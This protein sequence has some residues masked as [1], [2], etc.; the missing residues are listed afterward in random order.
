MRGF[1]LNFTL[2][3][4]N[5]FFML[6]HHQTQKPITDLE[7]ERQ[8]AYILFH[9]LCWLPAVLNSSSHLACL[10]LFPPCCTRPTDT[11]ASTDMHSFL[12]SIFEGEHLFYFFLRVFDLISYSNSIHFL[13]NFKLNFSLE[14]RSILFTC[15]PDYHYSRTGWQDGCAVPFPCVVNRAADREQGA[16]ISV[17][18]CEPLWEHAQEWNGWATK[19]SIFIFLSN[20]QTDFPDGCMSAY[21]YQ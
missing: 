6:S 3:V 19:Y 20:F 17:V 4:L 9:S 18:G 13:Q 21:P 11:S 10:V 14:L 12:G 8:L 1:T 7:L 2:L 16:D 5:I 15:V